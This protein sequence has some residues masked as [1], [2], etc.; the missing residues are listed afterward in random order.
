MLTLSE[1]I[2]LPAPEWLVDGMMPR[3]GF[4]VLY[5]QPGQGKSFIAMDM[6]LHI[7]QGRD[8][9]GKPVR[10]GQVIYVA[11]E[12]YY[13]LAERVRAWCEYWNCEPPENCIVIPEAIN[14]LSGKQGVEKFLLECVGAL[15]GPEP[16]L[17]GW[18]EPTG[19]VIEPLPLELIVIDTLSRCMLGADENSAQDV[20]KAVAWLDAMRDPA[21]ELNASVLV[22]HHAGKG[23]AMER[24]SSVLRGAAD[25]SMHVGQLKAGPIRVMCM[26]QKD[27]APF[28]P[29]DFMIQ[30]APN[31]QCGLLSPFVGGSVENNPQ[32]NG[33][34]VFGAAQ[35][36][37]LRAIAVCGKPEGL[38]LTDAAKDANIAVPNAYRSRQ[39]L[40]ERALIHIDKESKRMLLTTEGYQLLVREGFLSPLT[41]AVELP[42]T[43]GKFTAVE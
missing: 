30:Q 25:C 23:S 33:L 35:M 17:D 19:D 38:N 10:A 39:K 27:S 20:G 8:W 18:G 34:D 40:L 31:H 42:P 16:V 14:L 29:L 11:A 12:G 2:Q 28:A 9:W 3:H 5:G 32:F 4:N 7:A 41:E 22:V 6:A 15:K 13:S 36:R 24:G 37:L 26:K 43:P 21:N 1:L